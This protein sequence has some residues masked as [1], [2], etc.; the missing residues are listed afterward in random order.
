MRSLALREM[1]GEVSKV[2]HNLHD[3]H[4]KSGVEIWVIK[5]KS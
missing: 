3:Q 4:Q 2:M 1:N 5:P